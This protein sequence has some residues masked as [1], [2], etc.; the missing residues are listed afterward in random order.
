MDWIEEDALAGVKEYY[1][2]LVK[3]SRGEALVLPE[4]L[5]KPIEDG[6]LP[7][8]QV[9]LWGRLL[10]KAGRWEELDQLLHKTESQAV[11]ILNLRL[12]LALEREDWLGAMEAALVST[13]LVFHQPKVHLSLI[14][15]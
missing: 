2:R 5:L 12:M 3:V 15:I 13:E 14:H 8:E 10:V 1:L 6:V 9:V 7:K 11:D 4:G